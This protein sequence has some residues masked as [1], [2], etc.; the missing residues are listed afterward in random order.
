MLKVT[1]D[2]EV[3]FYDGS[4]VAPLLD[5]LL[6]DQKSYAHRYLS[7]ESLYRLIALA[8]ADGGRLTVTLS[9]E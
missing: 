9:R 2:N 8:T 1:I 3:P 5:A 4:T 7:V 6:R